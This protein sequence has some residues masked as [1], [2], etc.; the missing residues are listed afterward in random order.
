M[1]YSIE[2]NSSCKYGYLTYP[3]NYY[4]DEEDKCETCGRIKHNIILRYWPPKLSL[5]GGKKYPDFLRIST[6]FVN[7]CGMIISERTLRAFQTEGIT[8]FFTEQ[9]EIL[10]NPKN[11]KSQML[12]EFPNYYYCY[13]TGKISLDYL[14]MHYRKKNICSEC[15]QYSWSREKIGQS[16]LDY[17]T[18][19]N[20]DIC[21]L[22][23]YPNMFVCSQKVIDVIK[24]N[25][26]KGAMIASDKDIFLT[27]KHLK[28]C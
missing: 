17:T 10:D 13:V 24:H 16:V 4:Y 28:I 8:G 27:L 9:I 3:R 25:N 26:L 18:W 1:L 20:S 12:S 23:D 15:G 22:T 11:A 19:D 21:K 7:K 6:P 5:E 14:A 2:F